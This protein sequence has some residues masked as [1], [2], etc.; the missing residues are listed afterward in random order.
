MEL[1][2]KTK[3]METR[4]IGRKG[5]AMVAAVLCLFMVLMG[6]AS[7]ESEWYCNTC[8]ETWT[9]A[10][11]PICG[12]HRPEGEKTW[13]CQTCGKEW[14]EEF[15]FCPD[16]RTE[17]MMTSGTWPA[18]KL[19]GSDTGMKEYNPSTKRNRQARFGPNRDY[20]GA[21]LYSNSQIIKVKALL[22]E[23]NAVL[24]DMQTKGGG[25]R[26]VYFEEYTLKDYKVDPVSMTTHPAKIVTPVQASYGPGEEYDLVEHKRIAPRT[27][28]TLRDDVILTEGASIDVFFETDGWVFA[29]FTCS[30][31]LIRAW[32]PANCVIAK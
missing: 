16:D 29:E 21:G 28:E 31:G 30:I 17:K 24:V 11:C 32:I 18:L 26:C 2:M 25:R 6:T 9:T 10:W 27:G 5:I 1:K 3:M 7:A 14:S 4:K 12:E 8:K 19:Q 23:G 22:Q 20:P 15:N 13:I